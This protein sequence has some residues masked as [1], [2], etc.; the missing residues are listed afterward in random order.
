MIWARSVLFAF[1]A[2][3]WTSVIA[4]FYV[5]L[6]LAPRWVMQRA[7]AFWCRG[8]IALVAMCCG[9]R[10]Q[11]IGREN[12]PPDAAVI[13]AKHQSAWETLVF[14]LL[15]DDPVFVLK[16]ELLK[17][18]LIGWYM[19]KA[20]S[21]PID[22]A[23]GFRSIKAMLPGVERALSNGAQVIIFPEGTRTPPGQRRPYHSG[24]AAVYART[25]APIVPVALNSG[26]FW[27]RR[28]FLKGPGLITLA[29]LPPMPPGLGRAA[30]ME[31]LERRIETAT[32]RLCD[33]VT[34]APGRSLHALALFAPSRPKENLGGSHLP[35]PPDSSAK[36]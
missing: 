19:R 10:W 34:E 16:R 22:R 36:G 31:E 20:G 28:H 24:I 3:L 18:P 4:L 1:A 23:A 32:G 33:E 25:D 11:V 21:I 29:V 14:H 27:G 17:V 5:P 30:F 35:L 12:L 9:L 6:L 13:A 26:M 8:M 7:A 2:L 15:L